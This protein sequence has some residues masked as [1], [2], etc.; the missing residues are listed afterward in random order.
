LLRYGGWKL[1][2]RKVHILSKFTRVPSFVQIAISGGG[3]GA[4]NYNR[5]VVC[6]SRVTNK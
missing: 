1:Q 4:K 2:P 5:V 3:E 6:L